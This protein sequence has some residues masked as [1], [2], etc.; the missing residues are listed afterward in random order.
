MVANC[1][2][3]CIFECTGG[4]GGKWKKRYFVLDESTLRYY[5]NEDSKKE[6][7]CIELSE[8]RG[9]REKD[10]CKVKWPSE[11]KDLCFGVAIESRTYYLYATDIMSIK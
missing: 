10:Q 9:V 7:G 1:K 5:K 4:S 6:K 3:L 11:A 8:G 2:N